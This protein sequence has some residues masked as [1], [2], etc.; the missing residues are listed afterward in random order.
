MN[1]YL[2]V[3]NNKTFNLTNEDFA[4]GQISGEGDDI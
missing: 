3:V 1:K 2:N 4:W